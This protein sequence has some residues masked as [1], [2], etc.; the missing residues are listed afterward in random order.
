M[1]RWGSYLPLD[2]ANCNFTLYILII[3]FHI[4]YDLSL[5]LQTVS[6]DVAMEGKFGANKLIT[7]NAPKHSQLEHILVQYQEGSCKFGLKLTTYLQ[8]CIDN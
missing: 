2:E 7:I 5:L 8:Y 4:F 1:C 6:S 3:I